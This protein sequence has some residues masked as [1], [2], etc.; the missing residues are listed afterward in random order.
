M[1]AV[2]LDFYGK[3]IM[4]VTLELSPE[5]TAELE[6]RAAAAGTDMKTFLLHVV[7]DSSDSDDLSVSNMPYDSW[8]KEFRTWVSLRQSRNAAMD[9]SRESIYD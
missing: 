1:A 5:E 2:T 4:T 3:H 8:I 7:H 6:R 9:D